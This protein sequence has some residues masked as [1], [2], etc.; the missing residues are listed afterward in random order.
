MLSRNER[1]VLKRQLNA[2][3]GQIRSIEKM[4]IENR[5]INDIYI[6]FKAVEGIVNKAVY[7]IL[8]EV[9]RKN[10]AAS[11][12]E[13]MNACPGDCSDCDRLE[14]LKKQFG[15]MDLKEV[16]KYLGKLNTAKE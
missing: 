8:D 15:Q 3:S 16:S 10:L 1:K 12:V 7:E 4:I 6:Q 11:L 13:A 2:M 9:F 5:D 14:I